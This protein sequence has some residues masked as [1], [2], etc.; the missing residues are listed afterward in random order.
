MK[1]KSLMSLVGLSFLLGCSAPQGKLSLDGLFSNEPTAA[2]V[3]LDSGGELSPGQAAYDVKHYTIDTHFLI[4]KRSITASSEMVARA[5]DPITRV[6]LDLDSRFKIKSVTLNGVPTTYQKADGKL[7]ID[8]PQV[9]AVGAIFK[10]KV[11]YSGRPH[12][13]KNAP[14]LGGFVWDQTPDGAPW[15]GIAIQGEGCDIWW[16]C[17][18]HPSDEAESLDVYLTVPKGLTALSNGLMVS[19]DPV[20]DAEEKFHWHTDFPINDYGVTFNIAPY[21]LI[22]K[23]MT[24]VNGTEFPVMFW[25]LPGNEEKAEKL[26][27]ENILPY[28]AF[29]ERTLGPYPWAPEKAGFAEAPFYGMEH[30]S[31]NA[32]GAKYVFEGFPNYALLYHEFAHEYFGNLMT[33]PDWSDFWVHEGF[34]T[35]IEPLYIKETRGQAAYL[36]QIVNLN[37][38][39]KNCV[40]VAPP[41]AWKEEE[42]YL[43]D[44]GPGGDI[45]A[46]G[47]L[48]LRTL[49]FVMG[50]DRFWSFMKIA[51]YDT[52]SP[53]KLSA[54]IKTRYR[55]TDDLQRIAS[56][57]YGQDLSWFF[58]AY[59]RTAALPELEVMQGSDTLILTWKSANSSLFPMP[60]PVEINGQIR[61]VPMPGGH[62]EV[63]IPENA[64]ILVDP[65]MV[66]LQHQP[67]MT[68]CEK[69]SQH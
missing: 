45:Y 53:E 20:G 51:L 59:L 65:E 37:K 56:Q 50:E 41:G 38:G 12:V 35:F 64:Q 29:F 28:I 54:P 60:I 52:K 19:R 68:A 2:Q 7:F 63:K 4:E 36:A 10:T 57:E 66:V 69:A 25:H 13:A 43:S 11:T 55:S 31:L 22:E 18:D 14:W 15:I 9:I 32:Y 5:K 61:I 40:A 1:S 44:K 26:F 48:I 8:A 27:N 16:P 23:T 67:F 58:D 42:M 30:Q 3:T 17:K 33:A 62:A 21:K 39:L 24:S 49:K 47:A 46:K 6:E 34:A